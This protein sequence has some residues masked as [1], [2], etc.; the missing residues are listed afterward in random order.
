MIKPNSFHQ[1]YKIASILGVLVLAVSGASTCFSQS[2]LDRLSGFDADRIESISPWFEDA[3]DASL[4]AEAAKLLY[5]VRRLSSGG[6]FAEPQAEDAHEE[7]SAEAANAENVNVGGDK[8]SSFATLGDVVSLSGTVMG[9]ETW[10][11]PPSLVEVL[12]FRRLYRVEV[13][14]SD[15]AVGGSDAEG[16]ESG[17]QRVLVIATRVPSI[18]TAKQPKP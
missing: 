6:L 4:G 17:A 18:F 7:V 11:L 15:N 8:A 10:D 12:E 16:N 1:P 2:V 5:Q 3:S 14:V 13:I 9:L